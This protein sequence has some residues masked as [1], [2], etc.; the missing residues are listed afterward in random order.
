VVN[1]ASTTLIQILLKIPTNPAL[2]REVDVAA[3][4]ARSKHVLKIVKKKYMC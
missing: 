4:G 3:Q 2:H 1:Q